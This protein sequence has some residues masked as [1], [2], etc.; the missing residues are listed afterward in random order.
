M[1]T[2]MRVLINLME[3][4]NDAQATPA[5]QVLRSLIIE[6]H[7]LT[8]Q[9]TQLDQLDP[10][11]G[12]L[13]RAH[14]QG[15]IDEA[16]LRD[17]MS[18]F[19]RGVKKAVGG[20]MKGASA[21]NQKINQLGSLL[22]N[23]K[24]VQNFDAQF[25]Q[26]KTTL[27]QKYPT[28]ANG[29]AKYAEFAKSHPKTQMFII[30]VMT[31]A[32]S[33]ATGP[34]GGAVVAGMMRASNELLKGENLS[35]AVGRTLKTAALGWVAGLGI[36]Q[37][38]AAIAHNMVPFPTHFHKLADELCKV[39]WMYEE[40]GHMLVS[41]GGITSPDMYK[42]LDRAFSLFQR[43]HQSHQDDIA[44]KFYKIF[45]DTANQ[46]FDPNGPI[47]QAITAQYAQ[48][49]ATL[50][51]LKSQAT[52]FAS[53]MATL[54]Q[55]VTAGVQGVIAGASA[56]PASSAQPTASEATPAAPDQVPPITPAVAP[57]MAPSAVPAAQPWGYQPPAPAPAAAPRSWGYQGGSGNV[58]M[59]PPTASVAPTAPVAAPIAPTVP[60]AAPRTV[61]S[62]A[63]QIA[64]RKAAAAARRP[65]TVAA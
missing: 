60:A 20:A 2:S 13:M 19:G 57:T 16:P 25:D 15:R 38:G 5:A 21:I 43:Y 56:L 59:S 7:N 44:A 24:P 49:N 41:T 45:I 58:P 48:D 17:I 61:A 8:N 12:L 32:A 36:H 65:A 11:A 55:H 14:L 27:T 33:L 52:N 26:L 64:Q 35:T 30:G 50:A 28:L 23:T 42:T 10:R 34:A 6:A 1:P 54:A 9:L 51:L 4:R 3:T 18:G 40:N 31:A 62:T 39:Q 37:L 53:T 47:Q 63:A 46:A 29:V 22:Q